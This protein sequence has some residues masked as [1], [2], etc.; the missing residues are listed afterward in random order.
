MKNRTWATVSVL[1]TLLVASVGTVRAND[2]AIVRY[3][4]GGGTEVSAGGGYQLRGTIGQPDAGGM[5]GGAFNMTGG[6][7]F[8]L[9]PGDCNS[10]GAVD[11]LDY[12]DLASCLAGPAAGLS[13]PGCGCFDLD[14]DDDVDLLDFANFQ[15]LFAGT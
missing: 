12:A 10:D 13:N 3:T 9:V 4:I 7:W 1:L 8:P 15:V 2:F 14:R 5:T 11:L 6:F